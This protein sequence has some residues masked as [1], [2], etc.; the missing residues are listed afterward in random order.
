MCQGQLALC[1]PT[2]AGWGGESQ[3][4]WSVPEDCSPGDPEEGESQGHQRLSLG[5]GRAL[6]EQV[7]G[8]R[9]PPGTFHAGDCGHVRPAHHRLKCTPRTRQHPA[10]LSSTWGTPTP[11]WDAPACPARPQ[12]RGERPPPWSHGSRGHPLGAARG[13]GDSGGPVGGRPTP[14]A[15]GLAPTHPTPTQ[16]RWDC[17]SL[18]TPLLWGPSPGWPGTWDLPTQGTRAAPPAL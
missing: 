2:G 6:G 18:G 7:K 5:K 9:T 1:C 15:H 8:T 16:E 17:P 11:T 13:A 12:G 4:Q 10:P 14:M 3:P